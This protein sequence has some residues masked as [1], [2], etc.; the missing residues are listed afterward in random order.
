LL[1]TPVPMGERRSSGTSPMYSIFLDETHLLVD[2]SV[3]EV[4][5]GCALGVVLEHLDENG[6]VIAA[7]IVATYAVPRAHKRITTAKGRRLRIKWILTGVKPSST[8]GVSAEGFA[9]IPMSESGDSDRSELHRVDLITFQDLRKYLDTMM[10]EPQPEGDG[11]PSWHTDGA[12][13]NPPR[14]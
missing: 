2:V 12:R 6:L 7:E 3:S 9:S 10:N 1:L 8:F 14:P 4:K 11:V 13:L 5:E